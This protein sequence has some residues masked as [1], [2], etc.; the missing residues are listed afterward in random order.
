MSPGYF[1]GLKDS[2]MASLLP[3]IIFLCFLLAQTGGVH[4]VARAFPYV[5]PGLCL[6]DYV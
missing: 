5:T 2:N 4:A 6:A 3:S 1:E